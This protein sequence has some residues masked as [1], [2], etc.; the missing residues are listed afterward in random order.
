VKTSSTLALS[1]HSRIAGVLWVERLSA[2]QVD[3]QPRV[4]AHP[5][6]AV[7]GEHLVPSR[8]PGGLKVRAWPPLCPD[9]TKL[10]EV[11]PRGEGSP[12]RAL[13]R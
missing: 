13:S 6:L 8:S 10:M 11:R 12:E 9:E 4:V 3:P 5:D 1:A 2:N 7:E